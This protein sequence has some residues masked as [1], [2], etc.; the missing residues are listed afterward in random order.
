[1]SDIHRREMFKAALATSVAAAGSPS[2]A[3][4]RETGGSPAPRSGRHIFLTDAP[5]HAIGDGVHDN[6]KAFADAL[7]DIGAAGGGTL[8]VPAGIFLKTGNHVI[9]PH[10]QIVGAG[11]EATTIL[12]NSAHK[13]FSPTEQ[14]CQIKDLELRGSATAAGAIDFDNNVSFFR[15]VNCMITLFT[16]TDATAITINDCQRILLEH[17]YFYD[18]YNHMSFAGYVTTFEA[19]KCNFAVSN[20]GGHCLHG[21]FRGVPDEQFNLVFR[22][23]YFESIYGPNP[24]MFGMFG[25]VT[26]EDCG[27][28]ECCVN[29]GYRGTVDSPK[30]IRADNP[31]KL[32]LN[33][34]E[35]SGFT[36]SQSWSGTANFVYLGTDM[37][38]AVIEN[39]HIIQNSPVSGFTI[40][41]IRQMGRY[42]LVTLVGNSIVWGTGSTADA[43]QAFISGFSADYATRFL[44]A[45]NNMIRRGG[46]APVMFNHRPPLASIDADMS[47]NG[48]SLTTLFTKTFPAKTLWRGVALRLKLFGTRAGTAGAKQVMLTLDAGGR[49]TY[50]VTGANSSA[51]EWS[52]EIR[53]R[54]SSNNSQHISIVGMDR[55]TTSVNSVHSASKD[56]QVNDLVLSIVGRCA[57]AADRLTLVSCELERG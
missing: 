33:R 16:A 31:T 24:I 14:G 27:F 5:Y 34:C 55:S 52:A 43:E 50:R 45:E 22:R 25:Q 54:W 8:F 3:S 15:M 38:K 37:P 46:E 32:I 39:C 44:F 20:P 9:P 42:S 41:Y 13:A 18:N 56:T 57:N 28:E 17:C 29:Q 21:P 19:Y 4:R 36:G 48:K 12:Q 23:C 10:T 51:D 47:T 1:M 6:A 35:W 53:I 7:A 2:A 26:F 11:Y 40:E 49:T 30:V